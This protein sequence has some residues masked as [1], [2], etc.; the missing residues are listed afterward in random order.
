MGSAGRRMRR[1]RRRCL[2]LLSGWPTVLAIAVV[3]WLAFALLVAIG[4]EA[5]FRPATHAITMEQ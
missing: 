4:E 2:V 3:L 1:F 5:E